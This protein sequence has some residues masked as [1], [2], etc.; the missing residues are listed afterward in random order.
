MRRSMLFMASLSLLAMASAFPGR[1]SAQNGT[2]PQDASVSFDVNP[3]DPFGSCAF[4][5]NITTE[6]KGKTIVLPTGNLI[7]T[8]PGL[9]ATVTNLDDPTKKIDLVITGVFHV[10]STPD[11][12]QFFKVTGRN[13]LTDP[14][15]GVVLVTGNFSF[16]FDA[17]GNLTQPLTMKAGVVTDLCAALN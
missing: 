7:F 5:I 12:G 15:A 6:G 14:Y 9:R 4:P 10:T 16:A 8:S 2:P 17:A 1:V 3:G 11:G 13:L